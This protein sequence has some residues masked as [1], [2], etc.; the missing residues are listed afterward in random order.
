MKNKF[1]LLAGLAL[2]A[3]P[4]VPKAHAYS[5]NAGADPD[6]KGILD[7][8]SAVFS[9]DIET[10]AIEKSPTAGASEALVSGLVVMY[11]QTANDGY[12]VTRAVSQNQRGQN[13]LACVTTDSVATNDTAYH[14]CIN[15]GFAMVRYDGSNAQTPIEAGRQACVNASGIV[16]GCNL[17]GAEATFNTGIVPLK[18]ATDGGTQLP[19][20]INLR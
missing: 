14:R 6:R 1:L 8:K 19:V 5:V 9:N 4:L 16:R 11:D 18:S 3:G 10:K 13:S 20:L 12:T 7:G 17:S 15:Q 2:L